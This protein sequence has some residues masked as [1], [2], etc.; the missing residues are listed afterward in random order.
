MIHQWTQMTLTTSI[1]QANL[2]SVYDDS[3]LEQMKDVHMTMMYLNAYAEKFDEG[4]ADDDEV[5]DAFEK[6]CKEYGL[7]EADYKDFYVDGYYFKPRDPNDDSYAHDLEFSFS[8]IPAN[9]KEE[10][11]DEYCLKQYIM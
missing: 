8:R 10:S 9:V 1:G 11:V 3:D 6:K 2:V 7:E 5:R 4:S